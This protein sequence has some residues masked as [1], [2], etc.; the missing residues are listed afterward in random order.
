MREREFERAF[1]MPQPL[2]F[3]RCHN[4]NVHDVHPV[5]PSCGTQARFD[6]WYLRMHEAMAVYQY[7]FGLKPVGPH[8]LLAD[9]LFLNQRLACRRCRGRAVLTLGDGSVWQVCPECEGTGGVWLR[10]IDEVEALRQRVLA[11]F[12]GAAL[13]VTPHYFVSPGLVLRGD[14]VVDLGG[15]Q[16]TPSGTGHPWDRSEDPPFVQP[17]P[18]VEPEQ[19]ERTAWA[20]TAQAT[21]APRRRRPRL[22]QEDVVRAFAA[23]AA[24]MGTD[25]KVKGRAHCRRVSLK[26]SYSAPAARGAPSAWQWVHPHATRSSRR[27]F[28]LPIVHRAAVNL[29]VASPVLISR[30]FL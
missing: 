19:A 30:E 2:W 25:W 13:D 5:C 20:P 27:L 1:A 18:A 3:H 10:S 7:V 11:E 26:P 22:R 8:R 21:P 14:R 17:Q 24:A 16:A 9:R 23:A 15:P 29:G 4:G 6:G 12:P 28:A